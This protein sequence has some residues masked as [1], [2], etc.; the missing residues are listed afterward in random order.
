M[1]L[2]YVHTW[3]KHK[4][5]CVNKILNSGIN[6][7]SAGTF[8]FCICTWHLNLGSYVCLRLCHKWGL[9]FKDV[10]L[11]S[12]NIQIKKCEH[13]RVKWRKVTLLIDTSDPTDENPLP[14]LPP[15]KRQNNTYTVK[16]KT[17]TPKGLRFII[18]IRIFNFLLT[19][20]KIK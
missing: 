19:I 8:C 14:P 13:S 2:T 15:K 18:T 16:K 17:Y 12:F 20:F 11:N 1:Y 6:I 10:F 9:L 5:L 3:Q 7:S 4:T